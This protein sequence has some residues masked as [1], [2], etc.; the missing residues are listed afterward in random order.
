MTAGILRL[1]S[2]GSAGPDAT[3]WR[4]GLIAPDKRFIDRVEKGFAD[5]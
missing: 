2:G 1:D 5:G 4:H 3:V